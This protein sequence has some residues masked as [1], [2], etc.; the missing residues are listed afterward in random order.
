MNWSIWVVGCVLSQP[1]YGTGAMG[2]TSCALSQTVFVIAI[3]YL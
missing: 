2:Q 1:G 3:N